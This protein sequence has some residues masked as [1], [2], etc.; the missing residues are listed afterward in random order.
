MRPCCP[1]PPQKQDTGRPCAGFPALR[2]PSALSRPALPLWSDPAVRRPAPGLVMVAGAGRALPATA[3]LPRRARA[4]ARR[5]P[6]GKGRPALLR[7][8][9]RPPPCP[10][11]A[12]GAA[13]TG[14][15]TCHARPISCAGA[16]LCRPPASLPLSAFRAP[17][18]NAPTTCEKKSFSRPGNFFVPPAFLCR[19]RYCG[20]LTPPRRFR[21]P[22]L[23]LAI[24]YLISFDK[25]RKSSCS[26]PQGGLYFPAGNAY[27]AP[28]SSGSGREATGSF[29]PPGAPTFPPAGSQPLFF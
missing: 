2:R 3:F 25:L 22:E 15:V 11:R 29:Y 8:T 13:V 10:V 23:I 9:C 12:P 24:N 21:L 5:T 17:R 19:T 28:R 26:P 18:A 27:D 1:R 14:P 7:R 4:P 20:L 6:D 16:C